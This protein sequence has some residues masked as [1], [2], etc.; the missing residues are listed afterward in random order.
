MVL[1]NIGM[2]YQCCRQGA[3]GEV[4]P[5]KEAALAWEGA[6]ISWVGREKD[7]PG[8][9]SK[10][11]VLDAAGQMV[12]PGLIDCHTHLCFAGWRADEFEM[13][14]L[15]SG[16]REISKKGSGIKATVAKTRA[17]SHAELAARCRGFLAEMGA[18]GI[19]T[20]ECKSGYGLDLES[21]IKILE[22]YKEL[23]ECQPLTLVP[24]FLGAHTIPAEFKDKRAEYLDLVINQMLP[25]VAERG[26]ARFCDVFIDE[27]AFTAEE[28]SQVLE[29]A[30]KLGLK[31]RLHADQLSPQDGAVLAAQVGA[32]SADHLEHAPQSALLEM[33]AHGV[34][35]V[36]LPLASLMTAEPPVNARPLVEMGL[37]L[38]V[39]T[40]FNPGTAPTYHLPYVLSLAC[41]LNRLT[42]AEAL[43]AATIYAAQALNLEEETGSLE[44]GKQADFALIDAPDVNSWLYHFK[45]NRCLRTV[46]G[47]RTIFTAP[48][49]AERG[50]SAA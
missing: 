44:P 43:K 2:L 32:I 34:V 39:A 33:K 23:S 4:S 48:Q 27:S 3:Q 9:F 15:G 21:E 26:L 1:K 18:L 47:G 19:T 29:A 49:C 45:E 28:A 30:K 12:I 35:A 20:L 10:S 41:L 7:L 40:D 38:A 16:Y 25:R 6:G 42:P 8:E 17:A 46:K 14:I 36:F 13:R 5:I 31:P 37:T 50:G 22:V 24:T 11:P